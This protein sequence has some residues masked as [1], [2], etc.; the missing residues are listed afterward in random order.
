MRLLLTRPLQQSSEQVAFFAQHNVPISALPLLEISPVELGAPERQMLSDLDLYYAVIFVS[1]NAIRF[2]LELAGE[3]WPQWPV[4]V[5]WLGMG[6]LSQQAAKA[7][8]LPL[9]VPSDGFDSEAVLAMPALQEVSEKKI[10][11]VRG[12]EGRTV[13]GDTLELRGANID[14]LQCYERCC[15]KYDKKQLAAA[16]DA[17]S[18]IQVNSAEV[19]GHLQALAK[20]VL[21]D[22]LFAKTLFV[23]SERV[24]AIAREQG[25]NKVQVLNDASDEALLALYKAQTLKLTS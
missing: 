7:F 15:P 10:L 19:L 1:G 2:G 12:Q 18:F 16:F 11:I 21:A 25:F 23:I 6:K 3:R 5:H 24:A 8:H 22:A 14:Y 4:S 20:P 17:V 13:L 9:S